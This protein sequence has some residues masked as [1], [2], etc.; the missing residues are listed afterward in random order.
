MDWWEWLLW[1]LLF[2][3]YIMC[4]F[5][6]CLLTFQ[7]GRVVLGILGIFIPF[8]W[9]IGAILPAK[10]GSRFDIAQGMAMRSQMDQMT[11]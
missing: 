9:L 11:S 2:G 1:A 4:I 6:V 3:F 10:K 5:T 7:K 8:L